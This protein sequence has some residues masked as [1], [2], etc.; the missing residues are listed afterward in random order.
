MKYYEKL[1]NMKC[2]TQQDVEKLTGN[3]ETAKSILK[4]YKNEGYIESVRRNLYVSIS[5]E[6]GVSVADRF[7]IAS[8]IVPG[9]YVT[10]HSAFQFHGMTNQVFY[11]LYVSTPGNKK[12]SEF[13]YNGITYR[14]TMSHLDIGL[15]TKYDGMIRVTNLERTVIDSI[16]DINKIAGLEEVLNC[17]ETIPPRWLSAQKLVSYLK[18]YK[19]SGKGFLYK[20]IGYILEHFQEKID[21]PDEFFKECVKNLSR[22]KQYFDNSLKNKPEAHYNERW[23]LYVPKNLLFIISKGGM[24]FDTI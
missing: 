21:T 10:H 13:T 24:K 18:E 2:F 1:V 23:K 7:V 8:H 17:I 3:K 19:K 22:S 5:M 9:A 6:T 20:K 4:N 14:Y 11:E 16:E 15:E 12:F